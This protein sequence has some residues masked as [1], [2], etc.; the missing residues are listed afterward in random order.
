MSFFSN[1][2]TIEIDVTG[3]G[4]KTNF[5]EIT[6][7]VRFYDIAKRNNVVYDYYDVESGETPE[8][9]AEIFYGDPELHWVLLLANEIT[10]YYHDWAMPVATFERH[11]AA[12]YDDP[13]GIHHYE[14]KQTSG[15]TTK[16]IEIPNDSANTIP[17]DAVIVTNYE[18]Q[19]RAEESKRKIRVVKPEYIPKIKREIRQ[20]MRKR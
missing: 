3:D 9:L 16:T 4:T 20:L 19:E 5:V 15:D 6:K 18:Y 17:E 12:L 7:K 11:V 14:I 1:F 13:N 2:P 10:D 8:M